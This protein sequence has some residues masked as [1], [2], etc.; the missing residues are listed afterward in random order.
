VA[1]F[2]RGGDAFALTGGEPRHVA[3][4]SFK[5]RGIALDAAI[6]LTQKAHSLT[7]LQCYVA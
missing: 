7:A 5:M 4:Q 1:Q 6:D 3:L 2:P